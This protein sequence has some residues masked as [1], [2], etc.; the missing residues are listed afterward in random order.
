MGLS[1]FDVSLQTITIPF[2]VILVGKKLNRKGENTSWITGNGGT[3]L[4]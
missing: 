4:P 1:L 3:T 2:S